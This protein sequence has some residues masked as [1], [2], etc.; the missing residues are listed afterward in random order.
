ML[1]PMMLAGAFSTSANA[2]SHT[3]VNSTYGY[4]V[5]LPKGA[6]LCIFDYPLGNH[7]AMIALRTRKRCAQLGADDFVV[8]VYAAYNFSEDKDIP[9]DLRLIARD[10]CEGRDDLEPNPRLESSPQSIAGLPTFICRRQ[11]RLLNGDSFYQTV[12]IAYRGTALYPDYDFTVS[13]AASAEKIE[14]AE[15]DLFDVARRIRLRK[16]SP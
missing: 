13:I 11:G 1:I 6:R 4:S 8:D 9:P 10:R 14:Q 7:G 15:R 16:P 3:Y 5:T 2:E 12:L